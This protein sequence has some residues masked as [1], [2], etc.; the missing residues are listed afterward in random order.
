MHIKYK[1]TKVVP[2]DHS[3][4]VRYYTD[5]PDSNEEALAIRNPDTGVIIRNPDGT[6]ECCRTDYNI[7]LWQVPALTGADLQSEIIKYAPTAWLTLRGKT[8]DPLVDTSLEAVGVL[9]GVEV[10]VDTP[11]VVDT[12]FVVPAGTAVVTLV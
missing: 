4:V 6:I 8:A 3:I 2:E 12:V 7:T 9:L 11:P 1:I 5:T 10:V